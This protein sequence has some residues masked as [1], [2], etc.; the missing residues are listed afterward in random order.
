MEFTDAEYKILSRFFDHKILNQLEIK[1]AARS[2]EEIFGIPEIE[3]KLKNR[4]VESFLYAS[5]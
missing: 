2:I 5:D 3:P 4:L 1:N